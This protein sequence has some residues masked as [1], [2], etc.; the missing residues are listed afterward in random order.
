MEIELANGSRAFAAATSSS[1]VR[2]GSY[3]I[4][5]CDEFGFVPD[6]IAHE[7]YASTFLTITSGKTT[8]II[9]VSTPNGMNLFYRSFGWITNGRNDFKP[10]SVHWAK[11]LVETRHGSKKLSETAEVQK[12]LRRSMACRSFRLHL[13]SFNSFYSR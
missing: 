8:K 5:L 10:I 2:G 13:R 1:A 12:S 4:I 7:F 3:N 9:M 11:C 6:F